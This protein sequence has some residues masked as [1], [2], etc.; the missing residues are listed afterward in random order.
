VLKL[1]FDRV[2]PS[3][4]NPATRS[5]LGPARKG[6][7]RIVSTAI[8]PVRSGTPKDQ[9]IAQINATDANLQANAF[10]LNSPTRLDAFYEISKSAE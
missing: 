8:D 3:S 4:G 6:V 5:D 9:L 7:T 2:I 1:D 10:W